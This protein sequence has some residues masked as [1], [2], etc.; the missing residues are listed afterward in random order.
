M[1]RLNEVLD[2]IV[3]EAYRAIKRPRH[4][5]SMACECVDDMGFCS[6][7]CPDCRAADEKLSNKNEEEY[8][9]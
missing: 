3:R 2:D 9:G 1:R 8:D 6:C 7:G 4:C 5:S